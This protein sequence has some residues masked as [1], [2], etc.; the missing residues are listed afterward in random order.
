MAYWQAKGFL[1]LREDLLNE[2]YESSWGL[3]EARRRNDDIPIAR[4][5]QSEVESTDQGSA[6]LIESSGENICDGCNHEINITGKCVLTP[7]GESADS[8]TKLCGLFFF[9]NIIF[10]RFCRSH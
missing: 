8:P 6:S 7:A 3:F 4:I 9:V 10:I 1:S 2:I 5:R